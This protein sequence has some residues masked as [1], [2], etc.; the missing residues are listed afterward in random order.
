MFS[1]VQ[2]IGA[3]VQEQFG[4]TVTL[5]GLACAAF[6][7]PASRPDGYAE[8]NCIVY[9]TKRSEMTTA[10]AVPEL[11]H[12]VTTLEKSSFFLYVEQMVTL[13]CARTSACSKR[14]ERTGSVH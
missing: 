9:S 2:D 13:S 4:E 8:N 3:A 10:T 1:L 14:K 12:T 6:V 7:F 11:L 5:P